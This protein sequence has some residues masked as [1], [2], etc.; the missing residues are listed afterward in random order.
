MIVCYN[1]VCKNPPGPPN[2][3]C[4][5]LLFFLFTSSF[6]RFFFFFFLVLFIH[7]E[8]ICQVLLFYRD[9]IRY[10]NYAYICD[11]HAFFSSVFVFVPVYRFQ[12]YSDW[13]TSI[14]IASIC[15]IN[16]HVCSALAIDWYSPLFT[17]PQWKS[18]L[19][20]WIGIHVM[21]YWTRKKYSQ[22][23]NIDSCVIH[24]VAAGGWGMGGGF[25]SNF[26]Q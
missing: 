22:N 5:R 16:F 1:I 21:K 19:N 9:E 6:H 7:R 2:R 18:S 23:M 8:Q 13:R 17:C 12:S 4:V 11:D 24:D 10:V 15:E 26:I 20:Y 14:C 3:V 25:A